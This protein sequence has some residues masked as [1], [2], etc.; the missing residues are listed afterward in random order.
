MRIYFPR[1]N[2]WLDTECG[3]QPSQLHRFPSMS[4]DVSKSLEISREL[5]EARDFLDQ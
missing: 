2:N 3:G 4:N 5:V 1:T